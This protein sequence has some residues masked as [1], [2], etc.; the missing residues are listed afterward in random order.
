MAITAPSQEWLD[1]VR[2][3]IIDPDR[4]I[5]DPH[6]HL[7]ESPDWT[8]LLD[9]LW[10]DT[11][12]GHNVTKTVYL[13]CRSSYH[14]DGPEHL[15]PVGETK[16]VESFASASSK[17][18]GPEIAGIVSHANLSSPYLDEILD[19]H[20]E[21]ANGLFRGIR[22]SIAREPHPEYL[23]LPGRGT[24]G[25]SDDKAFRLGVR[26]L[27]DRGYTY[28]SWL[29]HHQILDFRALAQ[30][31]PDTIIILDHFGTPLGVGPYANLREEIFEQWYEDIAALAECPN[32]FAK[33]G[34][35][36]MPDNGFGWDKR[37]LPASSDE[38][39]EAQARYY[40]HTIKCFG[41]NRCMF[42]SNFPVDRLSLSY[43]VLWNGLKK[44]AAQYSEEE[45]TAM[46][47]ETATRIYKLD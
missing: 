30:S 20:E 19:A 17:G 31:A 6:H 14:T 18:A 47:S 41:P 45:Q 26:R 38:F 40:N 28:E 37:D 23:S 32:V 42:E 25:Q 22:H 15:K 29:Y 16:F 35:L 3:P 46:F 1:Q 34:G 33:L 27:G 21:A 39:V 4:I 5:V 8:Y 2:E 24:E 11:G 44:I 9:H 12:S 43:H 13:E 10:A 7:W 36:A